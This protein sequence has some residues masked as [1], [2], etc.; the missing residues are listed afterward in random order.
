ME[1][2]CNTEHLYQHYTADYTDPLLCEAYF[3]KDLYPMAMTI[4]FNEHRI[5]KFFSPDPLKQFSMEKSS[6]GIEAQAN[7]DE[8]NMAVKY[9][10]D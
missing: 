3:S 8:A 7:E 5:K 2:K 10:Q 9:Y 1:G 6:A 4:K